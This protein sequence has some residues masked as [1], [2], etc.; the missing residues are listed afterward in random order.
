MYENIIRLQNR[1]RS[2]NF[3][4]LSYTKIYRYIIDFE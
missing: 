3:R 2:F 1:V 4:G